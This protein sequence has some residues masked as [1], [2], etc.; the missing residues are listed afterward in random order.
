LCQP[1]SIGFGARLPALDKIA[2]IMAAKGGGVADVTVGG[3]LQ[4]P[5][6]VTAPACADQGSRRTIRA[7]AS[8]YLPCHVA[9]GGGPHR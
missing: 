8:R 1:G 4:L 7:A 3:C 6:T 9:A 5:D 2:V